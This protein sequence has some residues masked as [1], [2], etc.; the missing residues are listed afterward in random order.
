ML[1][2]Q[3][4]R[5]EE[6][7]GHTRDSVCVHARAYFRLCIVIVA[8]MNDDVCEIHVDDFF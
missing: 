2:R 6:V 3:E 5:D 4:G 7:E 8:T 1:T